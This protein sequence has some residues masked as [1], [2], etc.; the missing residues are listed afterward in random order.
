LPLILLSL[1]GIP[2]AI[3]YLLGTGIGFA[4]YSVIGI[5]ITPLIWLIVT[6]LAL[7]VLVGL[8]LSAVKAYQ[9]QIFKLPVIG[10]LADR[11]SA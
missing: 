9:G 4:I 11:F 2:L 10:G 8:V 1:A 3:L 7:A 6:L 5:S